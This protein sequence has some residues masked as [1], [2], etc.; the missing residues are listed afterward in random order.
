MRFIPCILKPVILLMLASVSLVENISAQ[1]LC[2]TLIIPRGNMYPPERRELCQ[3]DTIMLQGIRPE[4]GYE[5]RWFRNGS[6][7][8]GEAQ[9]ILEVTEAGNYSFRLFRDS[10]LSMVFD[11][12]R[13]SFRNQPRPQVRQLSIQQAPA[14]PG[15]QFTLQ[16]SPA[17]AG[18]VSHSWFR[19]DILES[20]SGLTL[21][22]RNTGR[23]RVRTDSAGCSSFSNEVLVRPPGSFVPQI[24]TSQPVEP[25]GLR[26]EWIPPSDASVQQFKVYRKK[27]YE[28]VFSFVDTVNAAAGIWFNDT[29]LYRTAHD[30]MLTARVSGLGGEYE[31]E[32]SPVNQ[33]IFL[34]VQPSPAGSSGGNVLNWNSY[35][36]FPVSR[37][38]ILRDEQVLDSV[39]GTQNTWLDVNPPANAVY[40]VEA[41]ATENCTSTMTD[42]DGNVYQTVQIGSQVWMKENLRVSKYRNGDTITTGL[43][44]TDWQNSTSGAFALYNNIAAN[45]NTYGKLYNW[46]AVADPRGLCPVGWRVPTVQEWNKLLLY[47]DPLTDTICENCFASLSAAGALKAVSSL[48]TN[49]NT[50][51]SNSSGFSGLPGGMRNASGISN[52]IRNTGNWWTSSEYSPEFSWNLSMYYNSAKTARYYNQKNLGFSVR[53]LQYSTE[54]GSIDSLDCEGKVQL[55][56]LAEDSP[57][58]NV[59]ISLPYFGGNG[60]V[61]QNQSILSGTVNGLTAE[62]NSGNFDFGSGMLVYSISG[63]P[64][65]FGTASFNISIGGKQCQ[66]NINV[67]DTGSVRDIDGNI[68]TSIKIGSQEWLQQNLKVSQ[69]RNGDTISSGLSNTEWQNTTFGAYGI[70]NN[71]EINNSNYGKLYNW[72]SVTDNRGLCPAGWRVPTMQD[73]NKLLLYQDPLVDTNCENC[74]A[75]LTA[76]GNLKELSSLWLSP[77]TGASNS[78]GFSGLPGGMIN[79]SGTPNFIQSDGA[80]WTST[81]YSPQNSWNFFMYHYNTEAKRFHNPKTTGFSVRCLKDAPETGNI[82]SLDC[83]GKVQMNYLAENSP[84]QNVQII[85]PY[86]GGNGGSFNVQNIS[87]TGISGLTASLD[88][89]NFTSGNDSITFNITGTPAG[90][91][92]ASF[93]ISIGGKQCQVNMNVADTGSVRDIDGNLYTSIKIGTQEWMQQNLRVSRFRTGIAI[94]G[95]LTNEEWEFAGGAAYANYNNDAAYD[96]IYGKLYNWYAI[97]AAEGLCPAGWHVPEDYEWQTLESFLGMPAGELD[98]FTL[99]GRGAA[100]NI[101]GKLKARSGWGSNNA[102]ATNETGFSGLPGG[103]RIYNG[104]FVSFGNEGYWGSKTPFTVGNDAHIRILEKTSGSI[105][106][107][108]D[109]GLMDMGTGGNAIRCLKD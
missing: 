92:T 11:T 25:N 38:Y 3:A 20:N 19:N 94:G 31:S 106:R 21:T 53:C 34:Q 50:A 55:N 90:I 10:C 2:D 109:L 72:Y 102:G 69:Y 1:S 88:A 58:E 87:S 77:N 71:L 100:Q 86:F 85:L 75:S 6:E 52:F 68:Y 104:N 26:A 5:M 47:Q 54:V 13:I 98:M 62:L 107:N 83:A 35:E 42:I 43:S 76:G 79:F 108:I 46:Y 22:G 32:A 23:Y 70:Y 65:G 30:V 33:T 29:I 74:S 51:A 15:S 89:G 36:G 7:L 49:P 17:N 57:A 18:T 84:A 99:N 101:G 93:S 105:G 14:S 4:N 61:Y 9:E 103:C 27:Y 63:T 41:P 67:A 60:G 82:D 95:G 64:E 8:A 45:N 97:A 66:I 56:Y 96:T 39:A 91:G 73:W 59:Q 40:R 16:L 28:S 80:W 78:S 37:Y 44:N 81:E 12:V 48:W 24:C